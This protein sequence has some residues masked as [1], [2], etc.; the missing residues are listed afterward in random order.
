MSYT[1]NWSST[2]QPGGKPA[3][4]VQEKTTDTSTTSLVL[5]GK[6]LS[7]Y[8]MY[9]QQNFIRLLEHFASS[10]AP[11]HP[12]VGQM[13]YNTDTKL[14]YFWDGSKWDNQ[15]LRSFA[16]PTPPANPVV[17][18]I[19]YDTSTGKLNV[20]DGTA[21]TNAQVSSAVGLND[22]SPYPDSGT[23]GFASRLNRIIGSPSSTYGWNQTD[24]VPTYDGSGN[25]TSTATAW[26]SGLPGGYTF[27]SVFN[28]TA[29]AI[30]ISRLRK[31]LRHVGLSETSTAPYG[32][33]DDGRPTSPGDGLANYYNNN[34][35]GPTPHRGTMAD[36]VAGWN[37]DAVSTVITKY[38]ATLAALTQLE[39]YRFSLAAAETQITNWGTQTR[40]SP[41][42][43][44]TIPSA[45]GAYVHQIDLT[46]SSATAA[47]AFFNAGGQVQFNLSFTPSGTP[48]N[49]EQDWKVFLQAFT[50]FTFDWK[51][52]KQT[53]AYPGPSTPVTYLPTV[54]GGSTNV[55]FYN[56]T[57]SLQTI[58]VRD[59]MDAPG[60]S[61]N[62]TS[63]PPTW[64]GIVVSAK[65]VSN[66]LTFQIAY[67]LKHSQDDATDTELTG[68]LSSNV[69]GF[70]SNSNNLNSPTQVAP[71]VAHSG[72]FIT[73][74]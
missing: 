13:W 35:A 6:G 28:N 51:G 1:V 74:A 45:I 12:T 58:F 15:I 26:Q 16:G 59:V 20:W 56:L 8:G 31:A 68:T 50:G 39:T 52:I 62:Y 49:V 29:W 2:G 43:S 22:Y 65:L 66:V 69:T 36:I 71:S 40:T 60:N 54:D 17:G 48:T 67:S 19:W 9:Q 57:S 10:I 3:I 27:P 4:V 53:S 64:G 11:L 7:N 38:N 23:T 34:S 46:F 47:A 32:F 30:A 14:E 63:N 24:Y 72:T 41:G 70:Y 18:Q 25:L 61:S 44:L 33:V 42:K 5:T 37:G 21:W 73:A 55:G